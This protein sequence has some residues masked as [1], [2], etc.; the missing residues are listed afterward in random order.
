MTVVA[1][2]EVSLNPNILGINTPEM[3]FGRDSD[4]FAHINIHLIVI[5]HG[6]VSDPDLWPIPADA[7]L[8]VSKFNSFGAMIGRESRTG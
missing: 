8:P 4:R 3:H 7:I 2:T 1:F 5:D 6:Y